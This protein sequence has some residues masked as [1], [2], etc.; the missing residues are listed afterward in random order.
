MMKL[1]VL[2]LFAVGAH[3]GA[4]EGTASNFDT[5]VLN[6]GKN[7]LVKFLAPW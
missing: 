7:S 2:A 1:L 5:E 3:A 4:F 6:S